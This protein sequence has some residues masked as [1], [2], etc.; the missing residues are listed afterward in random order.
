MRQIK[1]GGAKLLAWL[2]GNLIGQKLLQQLVF[3]ANYLMGVGSGA[4]AASSGETTILRNVAL[5]AQEPLVI[6]DVGANKGQFLS[7]ALQEIKTSN[8]EIHCFEPSKAAFDILSGGFGQRTNVILNNFA[9]AAAEGSAPLYTDTPASGLASLTKRRLEH[10]GI[11][12]DTQEIVKIDTIDAYCSAKNIKAISL[13][14]IDVE[15][16]ELEVLKGASRMFK[17]FAIQAITFEFGGCNIDTRIFFQDYW[18]F[19]RDL[20]LKLYR[21]TPSGYLHP[22]NEYHEVLEQMV[23]TNFFAKQEQ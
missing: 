3:Y 14:K 4:H 20:N 16:H 7:L 12:S 17:N 5:A 8:M 22:I 2:T 1:E 15:G 23:T 19:F 9:L 18:Y 13:L 11:Y 10:H 6:F 21:V